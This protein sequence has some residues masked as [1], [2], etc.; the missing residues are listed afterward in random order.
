MILQISNLNMEIKW[1]K[2]VVQ[3][4]FSFQLCIDL[5]K[6]FYMFPDCEIAQKFQ[7]GKTKCAFS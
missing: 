3:R 4:H 7:L 5:E 1:S 2:E 6:L